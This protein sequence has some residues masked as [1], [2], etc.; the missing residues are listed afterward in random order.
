MGLGWMMKV[1]WWLGL[2]VRLGKLVIWLVASGV[3][4]G[5]KSGVGV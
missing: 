1:E 2:R 4:E 5:V 3:G